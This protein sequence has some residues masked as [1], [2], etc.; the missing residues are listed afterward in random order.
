V[1]ER[2]RRRPGTV[3]LHGA[4]VVVD[5]RAIVLAGGKGAGKTTL[6]AHLLRGGATYLANDRVV[7]HAGP[8]G[9]VAAGLP[10]VVSVRPGTFSWFPAF[11]ADLPDVP[12]PA[13]WTR[14][15][16][17][18]ARATHGPVARDARVRCSPA[19]WCASLGARVAASAPLGAIVLPRIDP[20][21]GT[22]TATRETG[23]AARA[24]L[25][26]VRYGPGFDGDT[27]PFDAREG[28]TAPLDVGP[29]LDA[30][31]TQVP[32]VTL[33]LGAGAY[34]AVGDADALRGAVGAAVR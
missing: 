17:A 19:Q 24:A 7:V 5:G 23:A 13:H 9:P 28:G 34:E 31:A 11:L 3:Q 1:A 4:G 29:V 20:Q 18:A 15:E 32:V 6:L 27:T 21:V 10:T 30:L 8:V 16:A 25:H 12:H 22:Y 14:A 26:G 33:R 2:L